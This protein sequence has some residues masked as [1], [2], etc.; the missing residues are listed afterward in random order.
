MFKKVNLW[1]GLAG[2]CSAVMVF[3]IFATV[4]LMDYASTI[5]TYFGILTSKT[6]ER[7]GGGGEG[8]IFKSTFGPLNAE[9]LEKLQ[10]AAWEQTV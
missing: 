6:V 1:R 3:A 5:N 4:A 8:E 2:L 10:E 9:N 7:E